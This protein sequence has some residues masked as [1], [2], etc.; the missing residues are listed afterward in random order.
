MGGFA[1]RNGCLCGMLSPVCAD[2][3]LQAIR[4][5]QSSVRILNGTA[6]V[7]D[8][9]LLQLRGRQFLGI[10]NNKFNANLTRKKD[11][12]VNI[13]TMTAKDNTLYRSLGVTLQGRF[14]VQVLPQPLKEGAIKYKIPANELP[15]ET[16][17]DHEFATAF[18]SKSLMVHDGFWSHG[19][20]TVE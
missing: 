11:G 13:N 17:N 7:R 16:A 18:A 4:D 12:L 2:C 9:A 6:N 20:S 19:R 5:Y 3:L 10:T 15:D 8:L 14:G 1:E